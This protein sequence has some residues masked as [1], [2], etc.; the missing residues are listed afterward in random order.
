VS[1]PAASTHPL[2]RRP[3]LIGMVHLPPLPGAPRHDARAGMRRVLDAATRDARALADAGFDAVLVEN[4]GDA[5]FFKDAVPAETAAAMAVA[6]AAVRAATPARVAVGVN[7]LRNDARTAL[8]VAAA[9]GLS[10]VRVNVLQGAVVTDQGVVEGRAAE[11]MRTRAAL[12][13][14]VRVL[15]D[16]RVKHAAPLVE[17]PLADE[18][19]DLVARA[20][21]DAVLVTGARTG[22]APSLDLLREV[23]AALGAVPLLVASGAE[24]RGVA[25]ALAIA[26]GVIVGTSISVGR[27]TEARVQPARARA[28]VRAVRPPAR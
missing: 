3:T 17:R 28:F 7:V 1:R 10:F 26:D 23:R 16:L 6:A 24:A 5:P 22:A 15:A 19:K 27:R 8:A 21:A 2:D 4:Y 13:P 25:E 20:G 12:A 18:A 9:A 14:G 11:V